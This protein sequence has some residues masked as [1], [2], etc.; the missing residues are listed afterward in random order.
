M[1]FSMKI[2]NKFYLV[3]TPDVYLVLDLVNAVPFSS[4]SK[5][6]PILEKHLL[7]K[8]TERTNPPTNGFMDFQAMHDTYSSIDITYDQDGKVSNYFHSGANAPKA[9]K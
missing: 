1:T 3:P 7:V 8:A 9:K 4:L 6:Y 2:K 5:L